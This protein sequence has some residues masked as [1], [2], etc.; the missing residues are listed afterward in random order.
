MQKLTF[1]QVCR[2]DGVRGL[3]AIPHW[4]DHGIRAD[5]V[6]GNIPSGRQLDGFVDV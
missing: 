1:W 3:L 2:V 4:F 6:F 5:G